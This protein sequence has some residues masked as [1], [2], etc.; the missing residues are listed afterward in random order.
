VFLLHELFQLP[1]DKLEPRMERQTRHWYDLEKLMDT[2]FAASALQDVG[3][4]RAIVNHRKV[5]NAIRRMDYTGHAPDKIILLPPDHLW[6]PWEQDYRLMRESMIHGS[7]LSF[8]E[9]QA[10][11]QYLNGVINAL[12]F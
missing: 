6:S 11:I 10:R 1:P 5:L 4:Y 2:G 7:S 9:L 3:L 12:K 8:A